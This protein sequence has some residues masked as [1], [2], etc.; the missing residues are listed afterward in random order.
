MFLETA[1]FY[2][3]AGRSIWWN[4]V[5]S[6][7]FLYLLWNLRNVHTGQI[8][9]KFFLGDDLERAASEVRKLD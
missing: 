2:L 4:V 1:V 8:L 3:L 6:F 5:F 7:I 9:V